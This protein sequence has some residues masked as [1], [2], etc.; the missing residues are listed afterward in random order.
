VC[1]H[2]NG[3][4]DAVQMVRSRICRARFLNREQGDDGQEQTE[5]PCVH[6]C[7]LLLLSFVCFVP[8]EPKQASVVLFC[9]SRHTS[10]RFGVDV[11]LP[12]W[13]GRA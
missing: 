12:N 6:N 5:S 2:I 4:N 8:F 9:F 13:R 10:I 7:V 3:L 1:G 11:A